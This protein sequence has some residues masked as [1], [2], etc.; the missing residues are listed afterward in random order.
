MFEQYEKYTCRKFDYI[1]T[2]TPYIRDKFLKIN[3]NTININNFPILGELTKNIS[4]NDKKNEVCYVGGI[5]YIRGIKEV[6]KSLEVIHPTRLNLVGVFAEKDLEAEL[7]NYKGW[8]KVNEVGFISRNEVADVMS[9]SKAGI[10]TFYPEQN[11]INAQPNKIFEYMSAGLPVIASD[12]PLWKDIVM[13]NSCGICVDPLSPKEIGEAINYI[14]SS[15]VQAQKMGENGK[16]AVLEKYNW[17]IEEEK[18]FRVYE[19]LTK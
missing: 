8:S 17:S 6:V 5:S 3:R 11:H 1:I 16:K 2:A 13:G 19:D 7:K 14:I 15:P 18:L 12:F 9:D 4:W 10:V